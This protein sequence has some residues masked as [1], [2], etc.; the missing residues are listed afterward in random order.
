MAKIKVND[1]VRVISGKEKG[2][3]GVVIAINTKTDRV[4]VDG[5]NIVKKHI[6]PSQ[7]MPD[8][9]IVEQS[10]SIHRSNIML[11]DK[12][13][14]PTRV[15]FEMDDKGNKSRIAKTGNKL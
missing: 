8:G 9:G 4:I 1:K 7:E 13:G 2:N 11:I 3:E 10:G 15:G 14:K 5:L 6:K 12:K